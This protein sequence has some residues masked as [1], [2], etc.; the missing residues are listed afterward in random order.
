MAATLTL[1]SQNAYTDNAWQTAQLSFADSSY[2]RTGWMGVSGNGT[3]I[4]DFW[5]AND[6]GDVTLRPGIN[7]KAKVADAEIATA[8]PPQ[9]NQIP[10]RSGWS[11]SGS[12]S[13]Y[14]KT[15]DGIC[16][17]NCSVYGEGTASDNF[18][19]T[20]PEGFRPSINEC[21]AAHAYK[22]G[23]RGIAE[24]QINAYGDIVIY[25]PIEFDYLSFSCA[26]VAGN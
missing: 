10:F 17:V 24:A 23:V 25:S 1:Q 19:A 16:I 14:C 8:T 12:N 2:T 20:L 5:L 15:Q 22:N 11:G 3:D 6:K 26:F 9:A 18:I 7:G 13:T 4:C 21:C